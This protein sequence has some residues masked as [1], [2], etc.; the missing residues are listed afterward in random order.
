[1]NGMEEDFVNLAYTPGSQEE[2][3]EEQRKKANA[4]IYFLQ[5]SIDSEESTEF[6]LI[7]GLSMSRQRD[8]NEYRVNADI[9][10]SFNDNLSIKKFLD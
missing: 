10:A 4:Y 5:K 9:F 7:V 1:M 2:G 6:E 3:W 8:R